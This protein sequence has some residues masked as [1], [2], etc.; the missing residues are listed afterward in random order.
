MVA[1]SDNTESQCRIKRAAPEEEERNVKKPKQETSTLIRVQIE[2]YFSDDNMKRDS[3]FHKKISA[4]PEVQLG[5]F[6]LILSTY[7]Y[8]LGLVKGGAYFKL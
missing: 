3:F 6:C 8:L 1:E 5:R 2:Y 7:L 4:E